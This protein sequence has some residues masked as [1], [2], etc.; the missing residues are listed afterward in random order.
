MPQNK[1]RVDK[2]GV[3]VA[4]QQD[5]PGEFK[6]LSYDALKKSKCPYNNVPEGY[7]LQD[8]FAPGSNIFY[9]IKAYRDNKQVASECGV[10]NI[11]KV[12]RFFYFV[13]ESVFK[14]QDENGEQ[15]IYGSNKKLYD[16]GELLIIHSNEPCS[17]RELFSYSNSVVASVNKYVPTCIELQNNT[18]L[19][20]YNDELQSVDRS[21]LLEILDVNSIE[22]DQVRLRP[23]KRPKGAKRGTIIFNEEINKFEGFNGTTWVQL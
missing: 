3:S 16:Q 4:I 21:E 1:L 8:Q 12:G 22:F 13:R 18:L 17:L 15:E 7:L 19:G 23:S 6:L 14:V 20:C 10:G 9:A 2:W 11:I 5:N